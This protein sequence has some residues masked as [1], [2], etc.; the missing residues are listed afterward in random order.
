MSGGQAS[1]WKSNDLQMIAV[2]NLGEMTPQVKAIP[3]SEIFFIYL[4]LSYHLQYTGREVP[5]TLR[6]HVLSG[7]RFSC[8]SHAY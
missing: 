1:I 8:P 6:R 5:R 3:R 7:N 2:E 4:P